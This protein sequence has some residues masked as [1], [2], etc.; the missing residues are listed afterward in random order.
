MHPPAA[1]S[2][3]SSRSCGPARA[4]GSPTAAARPTASRDR[5]DRVLVPPGEE[6]YTLRRV[7]LDPEEEQRLLLRL[8]QR[9][10]L[11]AVP[12][13]PY[14][15]R[16]FGP[17]TGST[18]RRSTSSSPR[19][20]ADGGR[21]R[22]TRS[23]W[24]R[25]TTSRSLPRMI[26]QRCRA[27]PSSPSGTSPGRTPSASA[28]ARGAR[29]CSTGCSGRASW[30]PHAAHC[31]NFLESVDRVPRGPH[32]PRAATWSCS[33]ARVPWFAPT[34]S[35]R[36]AEPLAGHGTAGGRVPRE[37][38]R[39]S[40]GSQPTPCSGVGVDRL[41]YTKGIEERLLAVERLLER[42]PELR[43]RFT[44]AAAGGPEPHRHR[45]LPASQRERRAHRRARSTQRFAAGAYRP[46]VLLRAPP[47]AA[48]RVPLLPR[49][50]PLLRQ[51]P[52]RRHEP[53]GQGVR[54]GP[55]RR[56]RRSGAQPASPARPGS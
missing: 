7:W 31:N 37:R 2:R 21:T 53:R 12:P 3:R 32:R 8:L 34:R 23:S 36:V 42:G 20:C 30:V 35:R 55:R 56:A 1:S 50:R 6:S 15:A 49:R 13:R 39:P 41:D 29:N 19:P 33:A 22:T 54:R 47:R 28:S 27:P 5:H 48:R 40:S 45:A 46:I 26:R 38:V 10:A 16:C 14:P 52:P 25:T 51:Q 44:F 9:G 24:C 17:R 18:T 43:G 4:S 11:A